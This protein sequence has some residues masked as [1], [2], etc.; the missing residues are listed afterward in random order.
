MKKFANPDDTKIIGINADE[1]HRAVKEQSNKYNKAVYPLI[2]K[3]YG[4]ADCIKIIQNAGLPVPEHSNCFCCTLMKAK[5][6]LELALY[7]PERMQRIATLE[8]NV[9][10]KKQKDCGQYYSHFKGTPAE[11]YI[12]KAK[13]NNYLPYLHKVTYGI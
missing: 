1:K 9:N 8:Q 11:H 13:I 3:N 2:E 12:T 5:E 4:R 6:K 10:T 7:Y